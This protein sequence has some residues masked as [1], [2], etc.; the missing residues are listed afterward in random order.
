M[1]DVNQLFDAAFEFAHYPGAQNET[2]VKEF[3]DRF[4]LPVIFNALQTDPDIPGFENTLV[5]CL[6]RLFKTK[7]GASLIPQYMPVLQVGLKADSAVVKS[8]ACKTVLCLLED[9]DTNDVSS[10]QL[11]VNNGIYPLLLDYI[12][13][14]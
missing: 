5:T 13:N 3:L 11:V 10:V 1:E 14:R 2:S 6:E 8:L 4:P 9:C 12:I 7:Y